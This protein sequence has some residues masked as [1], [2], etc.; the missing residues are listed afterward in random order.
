MVANLYCYLPNLTNFLY[1]LQYHAQS[2]LQAELSCTYTL[3]N[4]FRLHLQALKPLEFVQI[5]A[6]P[7]LVYSQYFFCLCSSYILYLDTY[8]HCI[9][10]FN[11]TISLGNAH[12]LYPFYRSP[13]HPYIDIMDVSELGYYLM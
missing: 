10:T 8:T 7:V 2:V 3:P 13:L 1:F 9:L 12:H 4:L 5:N 11:T 6:L